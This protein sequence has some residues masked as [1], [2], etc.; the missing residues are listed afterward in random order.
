[1]NRERRDLNAERKY[2]HVQGGRDGLYY[3]EKG[4]KDRQPASGGAFC[5]KGR[6]EKKTKK[7]KDWPGI[8]V[9]DLTYGKRMNPFMK[10]KKSCLSCS[11]GNLG[12]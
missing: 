1:L 2:R 9:Y 8:K 4:E 6:G 5:K 12:G 7:R 10:K 3:G 11:R